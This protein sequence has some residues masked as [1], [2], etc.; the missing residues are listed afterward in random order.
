MSHNR[1]LSDVETSAGSAYSPWYRQPSRSSTMTV[2]SSNHT[3]HPIFGGSPLSSTSTSTTPVRT[4]SV[5]LSDPTLSETRRKKLDA[6]NRLQNLGAQRDIDLPQIVVIGSQSAGKSSLIESISGITLP[7]ASGTCTRCPTECRLIHSTDPWQCTVSLR[8]STDDTGKSVR[9]VQFGPVIKTPKDVE[10][11]LR[12]AQR[13]ILNPSI[14]PPRF[15]DGDATRSDALNFSPNCVSLEI[16]GSD[17]TDLSFCDLPGLIASV[18]DEGRDEDVE[19]VKNLVTSYI[20]KQ[21]CI[22]L[23][24]VACET[25][26]ETQG[27]YRLA[28]QYDPTGIRTIGVLTKPDRIPEGE[29]ARWFKLIRNEVSV[30][31]NGWYCVKQPSSAE[32]GKGLTFVDARRHGE[33][34]FK[35]TTPWSTLDFMYQK[36]LG[37]QAVIQKLNEFLMDVISKRVPEIMQELQ[38]LLQQTKEQLQQ[39]PSRPSNDPVLELIH[40]INE[41]SD[42]LYRQADGLSQEASHEMG[43]GSVTRSN[44]FEA[45]MEAQEKFRTAIRATAPQFRPFSQSGALEEPFPE[46]DFLAPEEGKS[47]SSSSGSQPPLHLNT[48]VEKIQRAMTRELPGYFPFHVVQDL[49]SAS[50]DKWKEPAF[51]LIKEI[52][53]IIVIHQLSLIDVYFEKFAGG[54]LHQAVTN[55]MQD[56]TQKRRDKLEEQVKWLL[57]IETHAFTLNKPLLQHYKQQFLEFYQEQPQMHSAWNTNQSAIEIMATV[58]AYFQV[59]YKRFVDTIPL[60]IDY[61]LVRVQKRILEKELSLGLK[62]TEPQASEC[63]QKLMVEPSNVS[64]LREELENRRDRLLAAQKEILA[65]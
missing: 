19:E 40:L 16:K 49:I 4:G 42:A 25:D 6:I 27:A 62:I 7:R 33:E 46:P 41:F 37:T 44:Q 51:A 30:L 64:A 18:S 32:L 57:K 23:L 38:T 52:D 24:T 14:D 22:I 60:A 20:Q 31:Q 56:Y 29:H 13:A 36:R 39:M 2:N 9:H 21:S 47:P 58:R 11:R 48:V 26:F 61:E 43:G 65:I 63:C 59:A 45:M 54:G 17:V 8:F 15:L 35:T 1:D 5:G 34:F 55:I 53:R 10:E 3:N 12:Q 28:K 50:T